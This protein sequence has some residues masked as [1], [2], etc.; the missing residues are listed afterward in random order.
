MPFY[1]RINRVKI[2]DNRESGFLFFSRDLAE[3][4]FT[5]MIVTGNTD[6]PQIETYRSIKGLRDV[7]AARD[8][9]SSMIAQVISQRQTLTIEGIRDNQTLTFGDTGYVLHQSDQ[10]PNDFNWCFLAME[11]DSDIRNFG[12]TIEEVVGSTGFDT[13]ASSVGTIVSTAVT[14]GSSFNPAFA[15]GTAIVKFIA[16]VTAK[17]LKKN[18]DDMI[19]ITYMSLDRWEHY[20]HGERKSD[21]VPDLSGNMLID[22]S[23]FGFDPQVTTKEASK[24]IRIP[25]LPVSMLGHLQK[26]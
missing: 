25:D 6:F 24:V 3:V 19:G 20:P 22:Y 14:V 18:G 26:R 15:A 2:L 11:D 12:A 21:G 17:C 4:K 1:F 10:I 16:E 9:T 8:L 5:S 7:S 23:I 13:F